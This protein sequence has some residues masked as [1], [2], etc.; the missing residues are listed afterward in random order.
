MR[1]GTVDRSISQFS[2]RLPQR[3]DASTRSYPIYIGQGV[4]SMIAPAVS[5]RGLP[6]RIVI[7]SDEH[8]AS[9]YGDRVHAGFVNFGFRADRIELPA[10][11]RNKTPDTVRSIYDKLH[12]LRAG[13]DSLLVA[14]GGG[15]IGDITGYA[16]ATY[17]R[18]IPYVQVPTSLLAQ[19]DSSVGGKV[20]VNL[21][22]GKNLIGAFYQPA[23]VFI[24]V[25]T[26]ST[27]PGR[28]LRSGLAEVVKYGA[29]LDA[30][31]FDLLERDFDGL[32]HPDLHLYPD[33]VK[34]CC[35]LKASVVA[36]DEHEAGLREILNFGHTV[37]HAIEA[38]TGYATYT[39]GEAIT[40]GMIA[41]T[42]LS[43]TERS[44]P[45][46]EAGRI[47]RLLDR[48]GPAPFRNDIGIDTMYQAMFG[49]KKVRSGNIRFSLLTGIGACT[50]GHTPGEEAIKNSLRQLV[51]HVKEQ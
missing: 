45:A 16:A 46:D 26:L 34:R 24:D 17:L 41:E 21:P 33:I 23:C 28:E 39:H 12:A 43:V 19:V 15:V 51:S 49:D 36:K 29:I 20:G 2:V 7:V 30:A 42:Y 44:L 13:R 4:L 3:D 6:K 9:L 27:L 25:G 37:G 22:Y 8:T 40:Y 11:E 5:E 14:V 35:E 38:S 50:F 10:G 1:T 31:L 32:L 48:L 47:I 18:G